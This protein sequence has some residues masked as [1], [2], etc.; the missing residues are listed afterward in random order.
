[1][2]KLFI[3]LIAF[4]LAFH[5]KAEEL[6]KSYD[7]VIHVD[8]SG[9]LIVT[10]RIKVVA[11]GFRI[12][13]G[14]FRSFPTRYQNPN[15]FNVVV[16]FDVIDVTR[17]GEKEPYYVKQNFSESIIYVG[18]ENVFIPNGT[19][20]YEISYKTSRQLGFFEDFDEL[21]FN[22]IGGQWDF[23]IQN[24]SVHVI[25]PDSTK[26]RDASVYSGVIGSKGCDCDVQINDNE[27]HIQ[28]TKS[29]YPTEYLT[30]AVA[31][32]KGIIQ[33]PSTQE[34]IWF[35]LRDNSEFLVGLILFLLIF[36]MYF[37]MWR[38]VGVDPRKGTI[39]P[40]FE[41][42]NNYSPAEISFIYNMKYKNNILVASLVD[43][44]I[45]GHVKIIKKTKLFSVERLNKDYSKLT[46]EEQVISKK[47]FPRGTMFT[48][49]NKQA[50][51]LQDLKITLTEM[52]ETKKM[53]KYFIYN[54]KQNRIGIITS[55]V[56]FALFMF[57]ASHPLIIVM[58][59]VALLGTMI[60]FNYL[61]KAPTLDGRRVMDDIEG[62]KMYLTTAEQRYLDKDYAPELNI[63]QFE[64]LLPYAI[65]LG[66]ENR[67]A[68]KFE[69]ELWHASK[70]SRSAYSPEWYLHRDGLFRPSL[71][72]TAISSSFSSAI[73]SSSVSPGSSSGSSGGGFSGG[74]GGGGG[75]GG[76]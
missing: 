31:F 12:K 42:P 48:F 9:E 73:S 36:S 41:P 39:I 27:L 28:T 56:A 44:A 72:A 17:N 2:Y 76:W 63:E 5:S 13:R 29:L 54:S 16:D 50:Q 74:G 59:A 8:A 34:K 46:P 38:R 11:E 26:L 67:W 20:E 40:L 15:G 21:Y 14:I 37:I 43:M 33:P 62:F 55:I 24:V 68:T 32:Q 57:F 45:K 71:L 60:L 22:A 6:I 70:E 61:L 47:L 1:M 25:F 65:A 4:I 66:V 7:I 53:P 51:R 58:L 49:T 18:D 10:E 35:F 75:G 64:K 30:F 69:M 19:H 3:C 23:K 52:L